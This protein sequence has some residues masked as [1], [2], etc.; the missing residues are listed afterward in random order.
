MLG[1]GYQ[2]NF[3]FKFKFQGFQR[4]SRVFFWIFQ[5]LCHENSR[6]FQGIMHQQYFATFPIYTVTLQIN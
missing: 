6:V 4:F 5:G 3:K 1:Q 2:P